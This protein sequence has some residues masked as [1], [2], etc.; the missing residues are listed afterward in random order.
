MVYFLKRSIMSDLPLRAFL[1]F[2]AVKIAELKSSSSR[3]LLF[4]SI[5]DL[6]DSLDWLDLIRVVF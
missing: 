1:I 6:I 4:L 2:S 3:S 5:F